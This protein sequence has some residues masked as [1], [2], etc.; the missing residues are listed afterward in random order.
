MN[1]QSLIESLAASAG[2]ELPAHADIILLQPPGL[3]AV[4]E[5]ARRFIATL[6]R[7]A[8]C[9]G[10]R[11]D[12]RSGDDSTVVRLAGEARV[13]VFHAS[14]ALQYVSALAPLAAPFTRTTGTDEL[15][16]TI[17]ATAQ[18]L[19]LHE[20]AG[21][22]NQLVFERLFQQKGRGTDRKG[23]LSETTLFRALGA[24]R[25]FVGGIPVLGAASVALRLAGDGQVDLLSVSTR[26]CAAEVLERVAIVEPAVAA[27][28]L[29]VQLASLLGQREL[30]R[31]MVES[32]EMRFGYL[33]LGRRKPQRVLAPMYVARIVLRHQHVRQGYVLAVPATE[34]MWVQAPLFGSEAVTL[35]EAPH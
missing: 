2:H 21:A 30:P 27:R 31:G 12:W 6:A 20:W 14:G 3:D 19:A 10:G 34:R 9:A 1:E 8:D 17:A 15:V 35:R 22:G 18:Q 16:H 26:P 23:A 4:H 25:Q 13:T 29:R 5:R 32:A 24:F 11:S 33:D 7:L 28:Q